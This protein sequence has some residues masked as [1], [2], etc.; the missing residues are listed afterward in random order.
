MESSVCLPDLFSIL[1]ALPSCNFLYLNI[2][3]L[4]SIFLY[5]RAIFCQFLSFP[6]C[7]Q[8]FFFLI[9]AFV[10]F[11]FYISFSVSIFVLHLKKNMFLYCSIA[12]RNCGKFYNILGQA[13][14]DSLCN[15]SF[16]FELLKAICRIS[17]QLLFYLLRYSMGDFLHLSLTLFSHC[18]K[19]P[20][21]P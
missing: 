7:F 1:S 14:F 20:F 11:R 12:E 21:E 19:S 3:F 9:P 18:Q 2:Y 13:L 8:C 16:H 4:L 6:L 5:F 15:D 17:L 10:T